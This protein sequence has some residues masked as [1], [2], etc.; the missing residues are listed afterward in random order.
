[1]YREGM[2][3][4]RSMNRGDWAKQKVELMTRLPIL[5]RYLKLKENKKKHITYFY[6]L[7]I[8]FKMIYIWKTFNKFKKKK[9]NHNFVQIDSK[10]NWYQKKNRLT[11]TRKMNEKFIPFKPH[12]WI[13]FLFF[14]FSIQFLAVRILF[15]IHHKK[16]RNLS[17]FSKK[18][19]FFYFLL[20]PH[21]LLIT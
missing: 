3:K 17:E 7:W 9:A 10:K 18:K 16:F 20:H 2:M 19:I 15:S 5:F 1:M 11:K 21:N 13:Q 8:N 6:F 4:E 12:H 14:D